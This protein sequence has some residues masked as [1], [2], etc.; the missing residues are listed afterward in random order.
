MIIPLDDEMVKDAP[1]PWRTS[2]EVRGRV[3]EAEREL[4]RAAD[5][6]EK[7][8]NRARLHEALVQ[9]AYVRAQLGR[10][11][12]A[13]EDCDRVL[14][15]D[16]KN[17]EALRFKGQTLMLAGETD[18]AIK[19]FG[20]IEDKDER[21]KAAL[22][23]AHAFSRKGQDDDV[24]DTLSEYW[25]PGERERWQ[26]MLADLLLEA[27]HR[28]GDAGTVRGILQSLEETWRDEPDALLEIGRAHV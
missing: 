28:K 19:A 22:A 18:Q 15:D 3:A 17:S 20:K 23:M 21:R 11:D 2:P 16:R 25:H 13:V 27:H 1:L 26:L 4:T 9:R 24:I 7:F 12:E 8:D 14:A 6:F 10:F 5:L